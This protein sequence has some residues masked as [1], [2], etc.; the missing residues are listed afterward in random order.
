MFGLSQM[1]CSK[2]GDEPRLLGKC[3]PP[4]PRMSVSSEEEVDGGG[5]PDILEQRGTKTLKV[6]IR[7]TVTFGQGDVPHSPHGNFFLHF[8]IKATLDY[9]RPLGDI[10]HPRRVFLLELGSK[11]HWMLVM[12]NKYYTMI[13]TE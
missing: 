12:Y 13:E 3:T 11:Q 9:V 5:E 8:G 10:P 6:G 7:V 4:P 2:V 1:H